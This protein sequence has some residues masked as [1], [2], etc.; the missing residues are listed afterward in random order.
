MQLEEE[1]AWLY[2]QIRGL[3]AIP[4]GD[5]GFRKYM[6]DVSK[7]HRRAPR[8]ELT[9]CVRVA[10]AQSRARW[11]ANR[12]GSR[13]V[14]AQASAG[15]CSPEQPEATLGQRVAQIVA[16]NHPAEEPDAEE[17]FQQVAERRRFL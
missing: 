13:D 14:D 16:C 15:S 11:P 2:R 7:A 8:R 3:Q 9:C 17:E 5:P 12:R 4:E 6:L 10:A 1:A